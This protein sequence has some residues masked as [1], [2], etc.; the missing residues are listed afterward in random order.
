MKTK[1]KLDEIIE[2]AN[3]VVVGKITYTDAQGEYELKHWLTFMSLV[4]KIEQEYIHR[5]DY[6]GFPLLSEFYR[7][8]FD[9]Y[10]DAPEREKRMIFHY[11]VDNWDTLFRHWKVDMDEQYGKGKWDKY[12]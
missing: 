6:K 12:F 3:L 5:E 11:M 2:K 8:L 1:S 9:I 10:D 4:T 7:F